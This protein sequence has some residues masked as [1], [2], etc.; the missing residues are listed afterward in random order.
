MKVAFSGEPPVLF[1]SYITRAF[2]IFVQNL[3]KIIDS[4]TQIFADTFPYESVF[5]LFH[6]N[7]NKNTACVFHYCSL[8]LEVGSSNPTW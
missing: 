3:L 1:Y 8:R 6:E 4:E 5:F 2:T 7:N